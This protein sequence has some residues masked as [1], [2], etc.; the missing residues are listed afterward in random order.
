[1]K[2]CITIATLL[3]FVF[4]AVASQAE[5]IKLAYKFTKG[6]LDKYRMN[7]SM[8]MTM[9]GI[10]GG[11]NMPPVSMTMEMVAQ[12]RTLE[13]LPDGSARIR[14]TYSTPSMKMTGAP[15]MK[16]PAIP[17]Q[18]FSVIMTMA[19]D[20]RVLSMEGM[21]KMLAASGLKNFDFSQFTNL[22]G[23]Y[24]FLPPD[25]VEVGAMWKQTVPM[26]FGAGDMTVDSVL[27]SY[28]EQIWS[29]VAAGVNTKYTA[30]MD[31]G[32]IMRSVA[33]S[34]AAKGK[35]WQMISQMSGG[36][37][38]NGTMTFYFAPAIGKVLKG[39]GQMW[40]T[41]KIGMPAEAVRQGA[42][43]ELC[44]DMDMKMTLTRFK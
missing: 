13:V 14:V 25:P 40:A 39:S 26:P 2:R 18:T 9:P 41:V 4:A 12:Q 10:P 16:Q 24:A 6:E 43:P 1:M 28:G 42:P 22:M 35:E 38:M 29:Q 36:I 19:P 30:H 31:L 3:L 17:K 20:G 7:K 5:P 37:D 11:G 23:Q 44:M 8:N 21:E 15:K 33:G 27:E 34:M 32:Q